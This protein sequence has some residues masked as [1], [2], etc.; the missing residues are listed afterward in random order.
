MSLLQS[1]QLVCRIDKNAIS[2][3]GVDVNVDIG[4]GHSLQRGVRAITENVEKRDCHILLG[5]I[6]V[7]HRGEHERVVVLLLG[8]LILQADDLEA[9][10]A[11]IASVDGTFSDKVEHLFVGVRVVLN[12][13]ARADDDSPGAVRGED[14]N[15]VVDSTELRVD[16]GLHFVPLVELERVLCNIG[17][18]RGSGVAVSPITLGQ[19]GLVVNAI[20]LHKALDVSPWLVESVAHFVNK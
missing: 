7:R 15:G 9:L 10:T 16:D 1:F 8:V 14:E 18:E 20:W 17:A 4:G 11:H 3:I 19:L 5:D 12:T 13:R 6:V 2:F